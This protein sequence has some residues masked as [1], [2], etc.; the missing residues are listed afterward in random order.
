MV[1]SLDTNLPPLVYKQVGFDNRL[2]LYLNNRKLGEEY[3]Y[4]LDRKT[5]QRFIGNTLD[6]P[7]ILLK[8]TFVRDTDTIDE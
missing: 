5:K 7:Q 1:N 3:T 6:R 4:V 2:S 8:R